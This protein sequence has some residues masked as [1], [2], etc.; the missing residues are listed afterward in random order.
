[1][2]YLASQ[3]IFITLVHV[4]II[5]SVKCELFPYTGHANQLLSSVTEPVKP[6]GLLSCVAQ[7]FTTV[8]TSFQCKFYNTHTEY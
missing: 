7:P 5:L 4:C 6:S 8:A 1:M 2:A 3:D